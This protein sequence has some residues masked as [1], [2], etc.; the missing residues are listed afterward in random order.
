MRGAM[1]SDLLLNHSLRYQRMRTKAKAE[2]QRTLF[3][4]IEREKVDGI[5]RSYR[6]TTSVWKQEASEALQ[7]LAKLQ[8]EI[9]SEDVIT[10]LE[11]K[12][13]TTGNNKAMGAVMVAAQR[14]GVIK[15]TDK[16]VTSRLKRRHHA[17]VR[18]WEVVR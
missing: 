6:N 17:P 5:E 16:W 14:A 15:A 10:L 4:Q 9:T 13:V 1:M 18:V 7:V 8:R 12:G 2:D 3:D 11:R